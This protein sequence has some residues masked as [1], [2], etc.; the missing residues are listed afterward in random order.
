[1][2]SCFKLFYHFF[3]LASVFNPKDE[4]H[5]RIWVI[6]D[7]YSASFNVIFYLKRQSESLQKE[8]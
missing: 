5:Y 4:S 6:L 1:M 8:F 7:I 3:P 2:M